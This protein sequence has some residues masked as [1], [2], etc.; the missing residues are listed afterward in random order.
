V[1]TLRNR[2][3]VLSLALLLTSTVALSGCAAVRSEIGTSSA[4]CY[5]AIPVA[6]EAVGQPA[7]LPT[8]SSTDASQS[9]ESHKGPNPVFAGVLI[10]SQK[11]IDA[12]GKTHNYVQTELEKRNGGRI[13]DV[14]L[15]AFRGSF[16]PQSARYVTGPV[17]PVGHR[18]YAIVVVSQPHN[19]VLATFIRSKEPIRFTHYTVGGGG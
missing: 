16:D 4:V 15:V 17:P 7:P 9:H 5:L 3:I 14:C 2:S 18:T 19:K 10:A 8:P 13:H 12:F 1:R 6:R 11:Q